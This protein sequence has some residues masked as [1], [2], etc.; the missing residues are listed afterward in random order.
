[1]KSIGGSC[2]VDSRRDGGQGSLFWFR[3]PYKPDISIVFSS[4]STSTELIDW[5]SNALPL[6][7]L[8]SSGLVEDEAPANSIMTVLVVDDSIIIQKTTSRALQQEGFVVSCVG[9]GVECLEAISRRKYDVI[10]LDINMPVMDGFETI[11]R[12]RKQEAERKTSELRQTVVGFTANSDVKTQ[13]QAISFGIL[14]FSFV[15]FCRISDVY[16][17]V[18][19]GCV[20]REAIE[21]GDAERMFS[22]FGRNG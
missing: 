2:G 22:A 10:L 7:I 4:D 21:D 12:I 14:S 3:I 17:S 1:M 13:Q 15:I 18:R 11:I 20:Y 6:R 9:N 16:L 8:R 5:S 19:Y